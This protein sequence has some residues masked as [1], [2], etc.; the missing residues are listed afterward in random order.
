MAGSP[1]PPHDPAVTGLLYALGSALC[2]AGLDVARKGLAERTEAAVPVVIG[3]TFAQAPVFGVWAFL[4]GDAFADPLAYALPGG[5]ALLLN[6]LAN[7]AFVRAVQISPLSV[8]VPLL[9]LTPVFT[10]L[11]AIPLLDEW[12]AARQWAGIAV[13]V[14][15]A[16]ALHASRETRGLVDLL[17]ALVREKGS[18]LMAAVALFWSLT[19]PLDKRALE[20][21]SLPG[22]ALV[23]TAGVGLVLL[24]YLATRRQLPQLRKLGGSLPHLGGAAVLAIG[25]LAL[26]LQAFQLML[27]ALVETLKRAVGMTASVA[28]GRAFFG[29]AVTAPKL[30]AIALMAAGTAL[31][32][33]PDHFWPG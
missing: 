2:W 17:K 16:F 7:V 4:Q 11:L 33:L 30:V 28:F 23:Q 5:A 3:L 6:V 27:V 1:P 19:G 20:H 29:E 14:V 21:A 9:S 31:L 22:H 10:G 18:A 13:V 15:G 25:A 24:L 12:P 8:T 32:T 26:Q